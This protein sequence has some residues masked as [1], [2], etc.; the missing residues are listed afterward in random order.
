MFDCD[1][2]QEWLLQFLDSKSWLWLA[3]TNS[4]LYKND[5]ERLKVANKISRNNYHSCKLCEKV[6]NDGIST[7]MS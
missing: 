2:K 1:Y 5:I 4:T 6:D 3:S 7:T